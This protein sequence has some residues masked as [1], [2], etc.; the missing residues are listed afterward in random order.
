MAAWRS[1]VGGRAKVELELDPG[2]AMFGC[3]SKPENHSRHLC[4]LDLITTT[5]DTIHTH[6]TRWKRQTD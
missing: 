4:F 3:L 1:V 5:I 2:N 6:E